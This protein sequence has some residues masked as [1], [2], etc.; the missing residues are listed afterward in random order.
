KGRNLTEHRTRRGGIRP[1]ERAGY[2]TEDSRTHDTPK[3]KKLQKDVRSGG[4]ASRE[5]S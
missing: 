1:K 5:G 4:D 3:E 2:G